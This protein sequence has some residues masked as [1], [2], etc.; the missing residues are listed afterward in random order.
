MQGN[1]K[2]HGLWELTA[3]A[4][5]YTGPLVGDLQADVVVIGGG[6]TG[7]SAAIRLAEGGVRVILLEAS[8]IGFGG[9]GRNVGLVNA[10]MWVMPDTLSDTLGSP[11]GERLIELLGGGPQEV[12]ALI[13]RYGIDCE[14][15]RAGTLHCAVGR[16]GLE[17]IQIRAE[18]WQKRGA[19][20][21]VLDAKET[22]RKIGGGNYTG[23]LLDTRA[24][25][26]Q[27]LAYARGLARVALAAGARIFAQTEVLTV[28]EM[29]LRWRVGTAMGSVCAEWVIVATDAYG[30]RPWLRIQREQIRLPYF[31]LATRP[32]PDRLRT[33]ILPERQGAWDTHEVLSS[34]RFDQSGRL[35]FGSVGALE[36]IGTLVH[37]AWAVRSL[38]RL[39]PQLGDVEFEA[40]W[41][42]MIGMTSDHLPRFHKLDRNL[43]SFG[44]YNGRGIAPG[45]VLGRVLASY[46]LGRLAEEDLPL[47][48]AP[49]E[50]RRFRAAREALYSAG[51]QLVHLTEARL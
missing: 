2:S 19:P 38:R 12:F 49:V 13:E 27:P 4:P 14:V 35:V 7:L 16:R 43:V 47:P 42:G 8:E 15:E 40:G 32:L 33:S 46:V 28:H 5:P 39:F 30:K 25:T 34:F 51:S 45:T 41:F 1:R 17:E 48:A 3:P 10:G 36:G 31:N 18:Q 50:Y 6:Y 24:G 20:V 44:G 22:R 29:G 37:R 21:A 9:S 23:A 11:F 26:I